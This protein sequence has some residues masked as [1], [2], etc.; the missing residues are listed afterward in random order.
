M[1]QNSIREN[2]TKEDIIADIRLTLAA[3]FEHKKALLSLKE[4]M[5]FHSSM[6]NLLLT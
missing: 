5:M 3:D 4:K 1:G 2:L 6:E